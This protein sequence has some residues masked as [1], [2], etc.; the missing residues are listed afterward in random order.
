[1]V[2]RDKETYRGLWRILRE[3]RFGPSDASQTL[4]FNVRWKH[5]LQKPK[6]VQCAPSESER[7]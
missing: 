1:M 7:R 6:T 5:D 4:S 3:K 2:N